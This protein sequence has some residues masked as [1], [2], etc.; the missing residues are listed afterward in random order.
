[1]RTWAAYSFAE[2]FAPL[3]ESGEKRHTIRKTDKG[4]N[5]GGTAYL[6]TE[7]EYMKLGEGRIVSVRPIEVRR[8]AGGEPHVAIFRDDATMTSD[9]LA[10]EQLDVF[11]KADGF[12]DG[13]E[14]VAWFEQKDGLPFYGFIHEWILLVK[15]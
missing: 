15:K 3:V 8:H 5:P 2:R 10:G 6:Y 11:A 12:A 9:Y 4:V 7:T 14:M 13:E 1:M